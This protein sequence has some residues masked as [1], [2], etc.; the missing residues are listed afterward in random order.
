M[1]IIGE[2]QNRNKYDISFKNIE[3]ICEFLKEELHN[4]KE[5]WGCKKLLFFFII[6]F[7]KFYLTF[8]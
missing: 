6:E 3:N 7:S 2:P 1:H 5:N 8:F 4:K